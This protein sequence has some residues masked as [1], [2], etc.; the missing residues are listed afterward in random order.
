MRPAMVVA[1]P[2]RSLAFMANASKKVTKK[3]RQFVRNI[4][5]RP[6][7]KSLSIMTKNFHREMLAF[8]KE[9]FLCDDS[10]LVYI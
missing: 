4:I 9:V 5:F 3:Q 8:F 6:V 7:K 2:W 1:G 10:T